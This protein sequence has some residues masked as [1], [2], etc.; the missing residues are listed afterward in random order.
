MLKKR[1]SAPHVPELIQIVLFVMLSVIIVMFFGLSNLNEDV[2][3]KA[4]IVFSSTFFSSF[5]TLL[6]LST[7]PKVGDRLAGGNA[8]LFFFQPLKLNK[9][10]LL[11]I[12]LGIGGAF[13]F[14]YL[15]NA[16]NLDEQSARIFAI[17]G[18]G[19]IFM[20]QLFRLK[21]VLVPI[22]THGAFNSLVIILRSNELTGELL[23]SNPFPVPE[24]G[25]TLGSLNTIVSESIFQFILVSPSE[26]FL[27][28]LIMSFVLMSLRGKFETKGLFALIISALFAVIMWTV[29]HLIRGS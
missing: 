19:A 1:S 11:L 20:Y 18:A 7:V 10:T 28:L 26:E 12:V 14:S 4:V 2:E 24:I 21:S 9:E 25:I 17:F 23:S 29:F 27:K 22:I 16:M 8:R 13:T 6:F 15:A 3:W 5:Y